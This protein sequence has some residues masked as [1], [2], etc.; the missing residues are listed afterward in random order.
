MKD[1]DV[2]NFILFIEKEFPVH[3]WKVNSID[4]WPLIRVKLQYKLNPYKESLVTKSSSYGKMKSGSKLESIK[5]FLNSILVYRK[6]KKV[7]FVATSNFSHLSPYKNKI[8]NKFY[9]PL[10]AVNPKGLVIEHNSKFFP[11]KHL[12]SNDDKVFY[13]EDFS[14]YLEIIY[15]KL[16]RFKL[17]NPVSKV[18]L[19]KYSE[20]L[21]YLKEN[22]RDESYKEFELKKFNNILFNI[23]VYSKVYRKILRRT[24]PKFGF[25]ICHYNANSIAFS[26]ATKKLNIPSVEIQHGAQPKIHMA[27]SLWS[28]VPENG[29]NTLP[30][31]YW[32]WDNESSFN[33][34]SWI[35][36]N[37]FHQSIVLGNPWIE[38]VKKQ[39]DFSEKIDGN[40]IL[41]SLQP[42][43]FELLFPNYLIDYIKKN[44]GSKWRLRNHPTDYNRKEEYISFLTEKGLIDLVIFDSENLISLP[45]A[46]NESILHV[47]FN[48]GTV[49]EANQFGVKSIIIDPDNGAKYFDTLIEKGE[50]EIVN[51]SDFERQIEKLSQLIEIKES[52]RNNYQNF[53]TELE[54]IS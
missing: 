39:S 35:S 43:N 23:D 24:K 7:D 26:L 13:F 14:Y 3:L 45:E 42:F 16:R 48:S 46:L 2:S 32:N 40:Y 31:I 44:K 36:E 10:L 18:H 27:Y 1:I 37:H 34:N 8:Y 15:S 19:P 4:I 11:K 5:R 50:A 22:G 41:Y 9:D 54:K 33:I 38:F 17:Y 6:L 25:E 52:S 53:L 12:Q 28:N 29:F 30:K 47:T 51:P 20:F 49:L 21:L